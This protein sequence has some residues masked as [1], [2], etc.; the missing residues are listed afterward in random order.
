MVNKKRQTAFRLSDIA[1]KI[2]IKL[3]TKL[4]ISKNAIVE[5]ALR[6]YEKMQE[7]DNDKTN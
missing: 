7:Q 1:D 4:G 5:L 3:S 2:L 6:E